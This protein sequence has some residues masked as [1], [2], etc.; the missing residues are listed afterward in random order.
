[1][2]RKEKETACIE[3]FNALADALKETYEVVASCNNDISAYLIPKGSIDKL[4]YYGKPELSFRVSDHWNWFS[5]LKKCDIPNY[6]QCMS[7]DMPWARRREEESKS[8]KPRYGIQV[9]IFGKDG[10]YHHV[11]GE[12]FD[13]RTKEWSWEVDTLD[14]V[15]R[16]IG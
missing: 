16:M 12:K 5:N 2:T 10:R 11:Y 8:T 9:A 13:R 3:F 4:S 7:M 6:V 1:M 15:I 14:N